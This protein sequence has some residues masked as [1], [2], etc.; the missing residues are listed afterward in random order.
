VQEGHDRI[1]VVTSPVAGDGK[2]TVA[3]NLAVFLARVGRK[4]LLVDA[5][6]RVPRQELLFLVEGVPGLA[7]VLTGEDEVEN[8]I[9][10]TAVDGLDLIPSGR[11][12]EDPAGLLNSHEFFDVLERLAE[13]YEH[14]ILDSPSLRCGPDA[15]TI[16]AL[17]DVTLLVLRDQPSNRRLGAFARDAL[18]GVG[19]N[20]AGVILNGVPRP[21]L[22]GPALK[23]A[24]ARP[25]GSHRPNEPIRP[26][27]PK[28][29]SALPRAERAAGRDAER[30]RQGRSFSNPESDDAALSPLNADRAAEPAGGG[31]DHVAED[32]APVA[33]RPSA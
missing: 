30:A 5:N 6:L 11:P 9:R 2:S 19:A 23:P 31:G 25:N 29:P 1:I 28:R 4:V 27:A 32:A 7:D 21:M 3:A 24:A 20:V 17:C 16:A 26:N 8:A 14:V 15:R 18:A 13:D 12:T 22:A 10:P 33:R